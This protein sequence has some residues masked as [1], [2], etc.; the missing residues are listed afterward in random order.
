MTNSSPNQIQGSGG[1]Y[2]S[3]GVMPANRHKNCLDMLV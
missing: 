2:G 3:L 1:K